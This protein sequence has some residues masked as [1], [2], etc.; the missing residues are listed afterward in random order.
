MHLMKKQYLKVFLELGH[1]CM[2]VRTYV[3]FFC[4]CK[5]D[6]RRDEEPR[7]VCAYMNKWMQRK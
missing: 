5:D 1:V 4:V 2:Y 6:L 3:L 7:A